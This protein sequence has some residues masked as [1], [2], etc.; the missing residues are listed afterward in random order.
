M[1]RAYIGPEIGHV[2]T[3]ARLRFLHKTSLFQDFYVTDWGK[4]H[5]IIIR[6]YVSNDHTNNYKINFYQFSFDKFVWKYM[7][8][9]RFT[10]ST[11]D[12]YVKLSTPKKCLVFKSQ[13]S[14]FTVRK[15]EIIFDADVYGTP[16]VT[17]YVRN[18]NEIFQSLGNKL[19]DKNLKRFPGEDWLWH[20]SQIESTLNIIF[21]NITNIPMLK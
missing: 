3:L 10:F 5:N 2:F 13:F 21:F 20:L 19:L 9:Y 11:L 12:D 7:K 14:N 18:F 16:F 17:G 4:S 1:Y 15:L 6:K 8:S